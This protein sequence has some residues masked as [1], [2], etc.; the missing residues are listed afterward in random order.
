MLQYP[1]N[2]NLQWSIN[3]IKTNRYRGLYWKFA[4]ICQKKVHAQFACIT[5]FDWQWF[6]RFSDSISIE[7]NEDN[8]ELPSLNVFAMCMWLCSYFEFFDQ[9]VNSYD[10]VY[11]NV[12]FT[13]DYF[14][15]SC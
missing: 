9:K 5:C 2:R 8:I 4:N 12:I 11:I 1:V 13:I 15:K 6:F 10:Y 14:R 7:F 3:G